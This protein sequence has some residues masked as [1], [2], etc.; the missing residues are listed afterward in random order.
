M[1]IPPSPP[2]DETITPGQLGH[3]ADHEAIAAALNSGFA[4]GDLSARPAAG[5]A[6]A[7][8][9]ATWAGTVH[10]RLYYDD[11]SDW[12]PVSGS[13]S[14][15]NVLDYGA[16]PT[17]AATS[18]AAFNAALAA[19]VVLRDA[20][21]LVDMPTIVFPSGHYLFST[22]ATTINETNAPGNVTIVGLGDEPE[23]VRIIPPTDGVTAAF[24]VDEHLNNVTFKN[25]SSRY[26][27]F[28]RAEGCAKLTLRDVIADTALPGVAPVQVFNSFWVRWTGSRPS[29]INRAALVAP[30]LEYIGDAAIVNP[31][32]ESSYLLAVADLIVTGGG[33]R[34]IQ[35]GD[36]GAAPSEYQFDRLTGESL[37][38]DA[39]VSVEQGK[40]FYDGVLTSASTTATFASGDFTGADVGRRI[41]HPAIPMGTTIAA[42][43]SGTSITL[44]AAATASVSNVTVVVARPLTV[45]TVGQITFNQCGNYDQTGTCQMLRVA[46]PAGKNVN[47]TF[48]NCSAANL[49]RVSVVMGG[50]LFATWVGGSL[51]NPLINDTAG[52]A[53]TTGFP[54]V[55]S[56]SVATFGGTASFAGLVTT[57]ASATG[58]SGLR[59][60]HGAAPSAPVDG[61]MWTTSAGLFV[62]IN[63]VTV[64][65]LT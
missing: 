22:Q 8:Y 65:P 38:G 23:A 7:Y 27:R 44:S 33:I 14:E 49:N 16:D 62:R 35:S 32:A 11:G 15:V 19:A 64:G 40:A 5:T 63:G 50:N 56:G 41:S 24:F 31:T 39:M 30:V 18:T 52:A 46:T 2:L 54:T 45:G 10:S 1:P 37:V 29:T 59:L 51:A 25:M 53:A 6:G 43:G 13:S 42:V 28:L 9:I 47:A 17:G 60:P 58:G 20:A 61:D 34:I 3:I 57:V 21:N 36:T 48:F 55:I 26:G 4:T 12:L